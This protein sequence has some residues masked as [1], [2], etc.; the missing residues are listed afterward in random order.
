MALP[1][2]EVLKE[3]KTMF[4]DY[5]LKAL[6]TLLRANGEN[7]LLYLLRQLAESHHRLHPWVERRGARALENQ[8]RVIE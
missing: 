3:L 7:L 2:K 5:D 4:P 8:S 6:N 1:R